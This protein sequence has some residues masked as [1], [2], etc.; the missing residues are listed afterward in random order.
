MK[1]DV[2]G[3]DDNVNQF[4]KDIVPFFK[5]NS[6]GA[7]V[8]WPEDAPKPIIDTPKKASPKSSKYW[9]D[10]IEE[11]Q[12]KDPI[13]FSYPHE[14]ELRG[15]LVAS[16]PDYLDYE[17]DTDLQDEVEQLVFT[18]MAL[19]AKYNHIRRLPD[20][21]WK[22]YS[23][24]I[25]YTVRVDATIYHL[26]GSPLCIPVCTGAYKIHDHMIRFKRRS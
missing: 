21:I 14:R 17:K 8:N 16:L 6:V 2:F 10:L 7:L 23:S 13:K 20:G 25:D 1:L 11:A 26:T 24:A 15:F 19:P 4:L 3:T 9:P 12:K 22:A 18:V 5:K